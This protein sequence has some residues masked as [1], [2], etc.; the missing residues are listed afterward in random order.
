MPLPADWMTPDW[1]APARVKA[2]VTTRNGGVSAGAYASLNLGTRVGDD[3]AAVEDNR[4][5]V[6]AWLP[7]DPRWLHQ[8]HG[9]RVVQ[10]EQLAGEIAADAAIAREAKVVCTVQVADCMPVLFCDEA[11]LS[12]GAAHAGWRGLAAGV[13]E[14]TIA[15]LGVPPRRLVAW[16]G[17]AIGPDHFEVGADV[18]EAFTGIDPTHS[19]LTS[20][21]P[22]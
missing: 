18:L 17:P 10:A 1:P 19:A 16:M 6:R 15:A 7:Q 2:F 3:S 14:A 9:T 13:L 11:G 12:V 21:L 22:W 20:G 8:V 5:R 4:A